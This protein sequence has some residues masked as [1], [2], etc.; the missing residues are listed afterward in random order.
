VTESTNWSIDRLAATKLASALGFAGDPAVVDKI[1]EHFA[2]H[3]ETYAAWATRN[4]YKNIVQALESA[5]DEVF[6]H[7]DEG[8]VEG[9][10]FTE[11]HL[12]DVIPKGLL[13]SN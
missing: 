11:A 6:A 12:L 3:R 9:F 5:A 8:L 13:D 7:V 10:L 4:A 1:A 2:A